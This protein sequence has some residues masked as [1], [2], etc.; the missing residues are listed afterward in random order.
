MKNLKKEI[1]IPLTKNLSYKKWFLS[2]V[3]SKLKPCI[4]PIAEFN[5]LH[6]LVS[7]RK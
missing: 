7:H 6:Q 2:S 1:E 3:L 4:D 5:R